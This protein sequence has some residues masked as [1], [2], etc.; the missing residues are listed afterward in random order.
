M[1]LIWRVVLDFSLHGSGVAMKA[2]VDG[3]KICL[4]DAS[5]PM[6][7][8]VL[9]RWRRLGIEVATQQSM[10][11][12]EGAVDRRDL[13][14]IRHLSKVALCKACVR[15]RLESQEASSPR[16]VHAVWHSP[17]YSSAS[18]N[19]C[20]FGPRA[21][22]R[23]G[24]SMII[25]VASCILHENLLQRTLSS[26]PALR[27]DSSLFHQ[28][29]RQLHSAFHAQLTPCKHADD[30]EVRSYNG[31]SPH[32]SERSDGDFQCHVCFEAF[33]P[34]LTLFVE[35]C[36]HTVCI[37]CAS[38]CAM[39]HLPLPSSTLSNMFCP[40][41]D[42]DC[43]VPEA[44]MRAL[45]S[46]DDVTILEVNEVRLALSG[47][48]ATCP[49]CTCSFERFVE[50]GQE[51]SEK[52]DKFVCSACGTEFCAE[53]GSHP[54]HD[55]RPCPT[56][57][58]GPLCRYCGSEAVSHEPLVCEAV[59]CRRKGEAS[60]SVSK[61]CGHLC[62]GRRGE[63]PC[64]S[65]LTE[66]CEDC[67]PQ[68]NC[69]DFCVICYCETLSE[70]PC[71]ELECG[72][73]F[74]F[75]CLVGKLQRRWPTVRITFTFLQCPLCTRSIAHQLLSH[76]LTPILKMKSNLESRF[77]E[78]LRIENLLNCD[79]LTSGHSPFYDRPL[80]YAEEYLTYYLC[81]KCDKPYFG[82]L[83]Q[84]ADVEGD[85]IPREE[86]VCGGCSAGSAVCKKHG[87][88]F[89]EYKCRYCCNLAVWYCWGTTHFC[90]QCHSPPRKTVREEC[91][92]EER[93]P[94]GGRHRPNGEEFAV[95][96]AMCRS[97]AREAENRK[98]S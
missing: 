50:D 89:M 61:P 23:E 76:L 27:Q 79:A 62:H 2:A 84:C 14:R 68:Q 75:H 86:L 17:L 12:L 21:A 7:A 83:K 16:S 10:L 20:T 95:G 8:A 49:N 82:G 51:A 46:Q 65:C 5:G 94:L 81:S 88:Q 43:C 15:V 37:A 93:C 6:P 29:G 48:C 25:T 1:D 69:E 4:H 67:H 66:G 73:V 30:A 35:E 34:S 53:C 9:R 85:D 59:G 77:I 40:A 44:E 38:R 18:V 19:C 24:W 28:E 91:P 56:S 64:T 31:A 54:Y 72:H 39:R 63:R 70:A 98:N 55:G 78:R 87:T 80:A 90:D 33:P 74:H 32:F 52:K 57:S 45:L 58:G 26:H 36:S 47:S 96:C 11:D 41:A 13:L 42:C 3:D 71:I 60:C 22:Y 92:G 97:E